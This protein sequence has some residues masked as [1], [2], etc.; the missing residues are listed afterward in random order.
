[1]SAAKS[2]KAMLTEELAEIVAYCGALEEVADMLRRAQEMI[3]A[4]APDPRIFACDHCGRLRNVAE[5]GKIFTLCDKC[6]NK[7]FKKPTLGVMFRA[8]AR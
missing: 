1:M 5:G 4:N 2:N 6:W 8:I 3:P 7:H